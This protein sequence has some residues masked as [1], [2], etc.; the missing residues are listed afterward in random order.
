M[1]TCTFWSLPWPY[2]VL[3]VIVGL[4]NHDYIDRTARP[5]EGLWDRLRVGV[6]L[7]PGKYD[8]DRFP[9][10]VRRFVVVSFAAFP[11]FAAGWWVLAWWTFPTSH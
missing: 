4:I 11:L 7:L 3:V 6:D 9:R 2:F 8:H 5:E 10:F 1:D